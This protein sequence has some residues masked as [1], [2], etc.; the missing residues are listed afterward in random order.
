ML[1]GVFGVEDNP[2]AKTK[3]EILT[4]I[5]RKKLPENNQFTVNNVGLEFFNDISESIPAFY[6]FDK[7]GN[8]L[9][10]SSNNA[11]LENKIDKIE[12]IIKNQF[13]KVDTSVTLVKVAKHINKGINLN[14][15]S[16]TGSLMDNDA[17][18]YVLMTWAIYV[19]KFNELHYLKW[20]T[21]VKDIE[22]KY[23]I[24][25]INVN[26]DFLK[27]FNYDNLDYKPRN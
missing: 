24:K 2:K 17:Q 19:G 10:D 21:K 25:I 23:K 11:C 13:I 16:F 15:E 9:K 7:N 3:E 14:K 8:L 6:L 5:V 4:Y 1:L 20:Y 22:Q 12:Y 26:L 18:Y 27:G